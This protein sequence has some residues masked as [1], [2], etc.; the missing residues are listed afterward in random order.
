[1][2][3]SVAQLCGS[4]MSICKVLATWKKIVEMWISIGIKNLQLVF[5]LIRKLCPLAIYAKPCGILSDN[6]GPIARDKI[7]NQVV[8]HCTRLIWF[9]LQWPNIC[10]IKQS[11]SEA[12]K[13]INRLLIH[14]KIHVYANTKSNN[15]FPNINKYLS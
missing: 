1:M 14:S 8:F 13:T 10:Y 4:P 15:I 3:T 2:G 6:F 12:Y 5:L 11:S 7:Q 9:Y